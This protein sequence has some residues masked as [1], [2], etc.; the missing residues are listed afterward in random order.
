MS[1][2]AVSA[3]EKKKQMQ[4]QAR[5]SDALYIGGS[6]L[7]TVGVILFSVRAGLIVGGA[8]CLFLPMLEVL[9]G[10]VRGLR[11]K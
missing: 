3:E 1:A 11:S 10:F 5:K 7:V 2:A 4:R 8:F 6:V 9:S